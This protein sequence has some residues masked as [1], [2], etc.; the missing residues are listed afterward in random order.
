MRNNSFSGTLEPYKRMIFGFNTDIKHED[1]IYHVQSEAREGEL[2]LQ[3]QVFVR[4]RCIGKRATPYG[5]PSSQGISDQEKEQI[6]R[7]QHR[8]VLDAIRDGHLEDVFNKREAPEALAGTKELD[9]SWINAGSIHSD[10]KL[11]M[12]LRATEAGQAVAGAKLTVR[13]S[14]N[15]AVPFYTQVTTDGVGEADLVFLVEEAS[16]P[17]SS[18]LV[19]VNTEGRTATRKFQLKKVNA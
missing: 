13:L 7:D 10:D 14:R 6:L 2:L 16:L 17:E 11:S 8:L 3:T 12:K 4:G 1:T 15:S 5:E 9:I 19:Q 18:I